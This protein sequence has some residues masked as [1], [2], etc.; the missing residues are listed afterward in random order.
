MEIKNVILI[1]DPQDD[2]PN[3]ERERVLFETVEFIG[4][5]KNK[6]ARERGARVYLLKGAKTSINK[7]LEEEI[8]KKK[9][10]LN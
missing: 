3:R 7:I 9:A 8:E 2:D 1:Q 5:I 10:G 4:E 6:F